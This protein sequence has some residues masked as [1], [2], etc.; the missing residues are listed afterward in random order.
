MTPTIILLAGVF[1]GGILGFFVCALGVAGARAD[2]ER[3]R[4]EEIE[5]EVVRRIRNIIE[6]DDLF[7]EDEPR[8]DSRNGGGR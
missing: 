5:D 3:G 4:E 2:E 6:A 8:R 7:R 1:L